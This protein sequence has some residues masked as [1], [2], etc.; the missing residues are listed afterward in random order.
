MKRIRILLVD[1][2][3]VFAHAAGEFLAWEE[4][5]EMLESASSAGEALAR[6]DAERPDVV[7]MDLRMPVMDGLEATRLIKARATPPVVIVISL[8]DS[9]GDQF[10]ARAAGADAFLSKT[11]IGTELL[12]LI[13]LLAGRLL[14]PPN[15]TKHS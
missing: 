13:D 10:A 6:M 4:R 15:G 14:L 2:S 5:I 12:G 7:L 8:D 9:P 11:R 1:D 3:E